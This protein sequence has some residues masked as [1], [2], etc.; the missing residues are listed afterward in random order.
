MNYIITSIAVFFIVILFVIFKTIFNN[1]RSRTNTAEDNNDTIEKIDGA[2]VQHGKLNDRIYL[3]KTGSAHC[4][5]LVTTLDELATEN[6]YSKI[7]AKIPESEFPTFHNAGYR[8]EGIVPN[9]YA[10]GQ[11]GLFIAR[12]PDMQR[13]I[14]EQADQYSKVMDITLEK[15]AI[16]NDPPELN[17]NEIIRICQEAD[18]EQM[19]EIYDNVFPS[20]PFPINDPD[21]LI[22][23]MQSHIKYFCVEQ[24]NEIAALSSAEIDFDAGNAEMTD[25]ATLPEMRGNSYAYALLLA[26]EKEMKNIG[27]ETLYT[28]ARAIS[29]GMNITFAR[30][31]YR[32][33]GRLINNT[34]I[35]GNIESMNIWYKLL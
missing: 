33:G 9:F 29:P 30:G 2:L 28:I 17:D 31:G 19:A 23:T 21:Y 3:M 5:E 27:I 15:V 35:S 7:F 4:P 14:E 6:Q 18:A 10:D 34:N 20:Y 8:K 1:I 25:F 32:F 13:K 24:N 26:M 16:N 22:E 12:Y 11:D